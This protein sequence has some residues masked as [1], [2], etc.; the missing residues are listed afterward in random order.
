MGSGTAPTLVQVLSTGALMGLLVLSATSHAQ[1][2]Q[3]MEKDGVDVSR[4]MVRGA[5]AANKD[6]AVDAARGA[7]LMFVG[8]EIAGDS[9]RAQAAAYLSSRPADAMAYASMKRVMKTSWGSKGPKLDVVVDVNTTGFRKHLENQ[10]M[11][12]SGRALAQQLESPTIMVLTSELEGKQRSREETQL[13]L[14]V[15]DYV[16]S[17][18]TE[19]RWSLVDRKSAQASQKQMK[20]ISG[21]QGM[22][23]DVD[24]QVALSAGADIYMVFSVT[25]STARGMEA[26]VSV[27]AKDV[28]T[29]QVMASAT[30]SSRQHMAGTPVAKV[31]QEALGNAMP[32]VFKDLQGYWQQQVAE[33][34]PVKVV[35]RG[36]FSDRGRY[37]AV[38]GALKEVGKWKKAAKSQSELVGT[39]RF[40]AEPDEDDDL[41]DLLEEA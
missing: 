16:T 3:F 32:K 5:E 20:A 27:K 31:L 10:G 6:A 11:A 41:E 34:R 19:R 38:K 35:V 25:L 17:F 30:E 4:Y 15:T 9:H 22:P 12:T 2:V 26:N 1:S 7:A 33:G 13:G 40:R 28:T 36:D 8:G 14:V 23:Q 37:K 39:L 24:A 29:A 21:I 18:L